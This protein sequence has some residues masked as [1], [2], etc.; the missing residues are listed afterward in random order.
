MKKVNLKIKD[1]IMLMNMGILIPVITF[2]YIITINNLY[3]NVI[4][5]S[6]DFLT[7]ES[8]NTQL[9]IENYIEKDQ[10]LDA[11]TSFINK[12]PLINTYLANKLNFRTQ[13]YDKTGNILS[14]SVMNNLNLYN[15]D[16]TD[17][18]NGNKAYVVKKIDGNMY[19]LFSSPIYFKNVT[20]GCIRYIYPLHS[21]Q[22]IINNMFVI[23]G[24]IACLSVFISW[25]LSRL[26]SEKIAGPIKELKIVSEKIAK[27]EYD[28]KIE[29]E[30][31][32]EI[33]DFAKTFNLT[34][35]SI[36]NY[37]ESLKEEKQKQKN[38]LDNVTHELKTPLTAIIGYSELI[39]RLE[40]KKDVE[41]SLIYIKKEGRRLLKLVEELLELSKI[42][43]A[44]FNVD[45]NGN[46]LCEVIEE[47][48]NVIQ[49]RA[50]KYDIE[51]I[52]EIFDTNLFIDKDKTKQV[53]LNVLDNAIKYSE[54]TS[55]IVKM[56]EKDSCVILSIID[57]GIGIEKNHL[58]KLFEPI[59]G[60]KKVNS[61]S[62]NGN[63]LGLC[64]C[65]EIMKKQN[66]DIEI[67]SEEKKWT[68]VKIIFRKSY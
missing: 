43:K 26:F 55:I 57:D 5:S 47:A 68:S 32:D 1:K 59:N 38:F 12:G 22:E 49:L 13:I 10:D 53:I 67:Y 40:N 17:S 29:I 60:V 58:D 30:S 15:E 2:I 52:K 23:M 6:I 7:K 37:I 65:K 66:G 3:S 48:L 36:K 39:P 34:T 18:I 45:R 20:L 31:G 27:G 50:K 54:C 42:G 56:E 21:G 51:I 61:I 4:K 9:Y 35:E 24:I 44:E 8:Y 28:N 63:G 41:D 11:E 19:V 25:I 64:I 33:E 14:D 46:N 62:K 16:I